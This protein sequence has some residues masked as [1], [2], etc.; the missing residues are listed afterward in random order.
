MR[1]IVLG[2]AITYCLLVSASGYAQF[3]SVGPCKGGGSIANATESPFKGHAHDLLRS[4]DIRSKHISLT[5]DQPTWLKDLMGPSAPNKMYWKGEAT[6]VI[7]STCKPRSCSED[8]AVGLYEPGPGNYGLV[9]TKNKKQV[10]SGHISP[11]AREALAC[12]DELSAESAKAVDQSIR[13]PER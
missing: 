13:A 1:H 8:T 7:L 10:E 11:L 2:S 6:V 12:L 5:R 9:V 4:A 3:D